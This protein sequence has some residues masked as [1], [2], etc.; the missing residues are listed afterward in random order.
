MFWLFDK[1]IKPSY[2]F[3][4][5]FELDESQIDLDSIYKLDLDTFPSMSGNNYLNIV[6]EKNIKPL[7]INYCIKIIGNFISY[8]DIE[9]GKTINFTK[10]EQFIK[11]SDNK[12]KKPIFDFNYT[13]VTN[14]KIPELLSK[15]YDFNYPDIKFELFQINSNL[16]LIKEHNQSDNSKRNY[17]IAKKN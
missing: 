10:Q 13:L 4:Q 15:T 11:P 9:S 5:I 6:N 17:I 2:N 7:I 14:N 3:I 8:T 1:D 16:I 12:F